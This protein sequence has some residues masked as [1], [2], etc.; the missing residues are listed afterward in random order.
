M[1]PAKHLGDLKDFW[2][3]FGYLEGRRRPFGA[4]MGSGGTPKGA[5]L[6]GNCTYNGV[7]SAKIG[8]KMADFGRGHFLLRKKCIFLFW[9]HFY[10]VKCLWGHLLEKI[11]FLRFSTIRRVFRSKGSQRDPFWPAFRG[12]LVTWRSGF[13]E[14]FGSPVRLRGAQGA[15]WDPFRVPKLEG[16]RDGFVTES[17]SKIYFWNWFQKV[18]FLV[19]FSA[20]GL[21]A[22]GGTRPT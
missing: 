12:L 1:G 5:I 4:S 20:G 16:E 17:F 22:S 8:H 6:E 13:G 9:F 11:S 10:G 2:G 3:S 7:F 14:G 18:Y 19:S 21:T 15:F